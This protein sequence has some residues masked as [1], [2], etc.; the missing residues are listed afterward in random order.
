[1]NDLIKQYREEADRLEKYISKLKKQ[2]LKTG[3]C[4]LEIKL[5]R[6]IILLERELFEIKRDISLMEK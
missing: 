4:E 2:L 5:R 1:M 3:N 6:R